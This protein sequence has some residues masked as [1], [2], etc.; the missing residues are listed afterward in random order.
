MPH[1]RQTIRDALVALLVAAGTNAGS[2]VYG[3]R[4][5][6]TSETELPVILV[7]T[8]DETAV[9]RDLSS[10]TSIRSLNVKIRIKCLVNGT[11]DDSLDTLADQIEAAIRGSISISG[12]ALAAIYQNTEITFDSDGETESGVAELSYEV[13]YIQ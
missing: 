13:K 1:K 7:Y 11:V 6:A 12:T 4:E 10:K 3:S 9:S 8:K 5:T 2:R